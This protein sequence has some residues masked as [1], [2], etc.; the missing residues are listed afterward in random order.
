MTDSTSI[1]S[2]PTS[3]GGNVQLGVTEQR[4]TTQPVQQQQVGYG[5]QMDQ[6]L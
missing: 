1:N 4:S 3:I 6:E 5:V 2:L